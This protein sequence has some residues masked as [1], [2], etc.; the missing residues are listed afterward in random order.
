MFI[1]FFKWRRHKQKV[2][3]RLIKF[4]HCQHALKFEYLKDLDADTYWKCMYPKEDQSHE[5]T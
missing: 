5:R 3:E 1:E 2:R 4:V